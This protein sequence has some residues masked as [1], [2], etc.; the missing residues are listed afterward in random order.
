METLL[1]RKTLQQDYGPAM[2]SLPDG[3]LVPNE[4]TIARSRGIQNLRATYSGWVG[5][6]EA[7]IFL[8]G[9]EAGAQWSRDTDTQ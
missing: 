7:E 6:V 3:S 1:A 5:V 2:R 9:F 4:K 8:I